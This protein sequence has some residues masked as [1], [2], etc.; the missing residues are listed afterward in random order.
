MGNILTGIFAAKW[1][2]GLDGIVIP[3]GAIEGNGIFV[4]YAFVSATSVAL[5]SFVVTLIILVLMNWIPGMHFRS[6]EVRAF[7]QVDVPNF[8]FSSRSW[9]FLEVTGVKWANW[10]KWTPSKKE[11]PCFGIQL[12][13]WLEMHQFP[14]LTLP[15]CDKCQSTRQREITN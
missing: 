8:S 12:A 10:S 4:G 13:S 1:V 14:W 6:S 2:A 9:S 3:G 11:K 7:L 5:W 15:V